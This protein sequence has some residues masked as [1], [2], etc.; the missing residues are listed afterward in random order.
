MS[1]KL[2]V[3]CTNFSVNAVTVSGASSLKIVANT[4]QIHDGPI[5]PQAFEKP[6]MDTWGEARSASLKTIIAGCFLISAVASG[7]LIIFNIFTVSAATMKWGE[8]EGCNA[9]SALHLT[10]GIGIVSESRFDDR[11]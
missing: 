11:E 1:S 2:K 3:N 7:V 9:F 10:E 5:Q 8:L 4:R 6:M